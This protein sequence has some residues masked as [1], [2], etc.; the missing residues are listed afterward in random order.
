MVISGM[1]IEQRMG[2]AQADKG[3]RARLTDRS[4][5]GTAGCRGTARN[6]VSPQCRVQ[7]GDGG[8]K[9]SIGAG[10]Q[11]WLS[12]EVSRS[13]VCCIWMTGGE[14]DSQV[15]RCPLPT[16]SAAQE[17]RATPPPPLCPQALFSRV[18][19]PLV[20]LQQLLSI[21]FPY[22]VSDSCLFSLTRPRP[23]PQG[24]V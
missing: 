14:Q 21:V 4:Q 24:D 11:P 20:W 6:S 22:F 10:P 3:D 19:V 15:S 2:I 5:L 17:P 7:G 9:A 1:G 12:L 13:A 16:S 8:N 18:Y 23:S